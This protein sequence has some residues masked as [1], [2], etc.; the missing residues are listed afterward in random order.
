[1][2]PMIDFHCYS[3]Y[4]WFSQ[5]FTETDGTFAQ[6]L[7]ECSVSREELAAFG[8]RLPKPPQEKGGAH[9]MKIYVLFSLNIF[10]LNIHFR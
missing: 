7:E 6:R 10:F 2:V 1:M 3:S 4:L 8:A 9:R 5:G